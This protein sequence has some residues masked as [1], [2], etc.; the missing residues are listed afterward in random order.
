MGAE[1]RTAGAVEVRRATAADVEELLDLIEDVA[2]EGRWLG[3]EAPID[4]EARREIL[5][6]GLT[7]DEEAARFVAVADGRIVG[8]IDVHRE[9]TGVADLGMAVVLGWRGQG[10]G[11]ALMDAALGWC[12][13][14]GSARIH[15]VAL[16]AWPHNAPALA[17]YRR[18]G[19]ATEGTLTRHYRR[20]D[21]SLWDAV[22]MGLGLDDESPGAPERW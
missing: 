21:G 17:L 3:S 15:K 19:F 22:V 11:R 4:R 2:A 13:E 12:R 5:G 6:R 1:D 16:Q 14:Q 18:M 8:S 10:V 7:G 9:P 20:R